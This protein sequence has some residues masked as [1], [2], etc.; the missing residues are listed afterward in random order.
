VTEAQLSEAFATVLKQ[1]PKERAT[2][3]LPRLPTP[4]PKTVSLIFYYQ[5]APKMP[6]N[7]A[8]RN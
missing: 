4:V 8:S 2:H 7:I 6:K 5:L 1:E 3:L